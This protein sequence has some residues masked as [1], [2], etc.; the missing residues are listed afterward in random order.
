MWMCLAY[1]PSLRLCE[2]LSQ[3]NCMSTLQDLHACCKI[4]QKCIIA[5]VSYMY[6]FFIILLNWENLGHKIGFQVS[7]C[8]WLV[9]YD[10]RRIRL[11][12]QISWLDVHVQINYLPILSGL[13]RQKVVFFKVK[14]HK[15]FSDLLWSAIC[16]VHAA[17]FEDVTTS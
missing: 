2:V 6:A 9:W 14:T 3:L 16:Y 12:A 17:H 15:V 13:L 11:F 7:F 4:I 10:T 1:Y 8:Y 5:Q